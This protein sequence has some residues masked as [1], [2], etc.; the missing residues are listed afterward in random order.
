MYELLLDRHAERQ[1][2]KLTLDDTFERIDKAIRGLAL[3]P[4]PHGVV[5]LLGNTHRI[6]VGDYRII[7]SVN[8]EDRVVLVAEIRYRN[9]RTYRGL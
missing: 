2:D 1:L 9:E 4:R 5:K 8:D 3:N 6:R 7:Y